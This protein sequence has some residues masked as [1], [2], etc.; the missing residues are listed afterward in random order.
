MKFSPKHTHRKPHYHHQGA[1]VI[2]VG[3]VFCVKGLCERQ[4][5]GNVF[6]PAQKAADVQDADLSDADA[7]LHFQLRVRLELAVA[8][9]LVPRELLFDLRV[10]WCRKL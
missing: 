2:G 10:W 7:K 6:H 4:S 5:G 1:I 3:V 8:E 9:D